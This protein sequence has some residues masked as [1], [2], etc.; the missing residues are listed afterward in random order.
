MTLSAVVSRACTLA[1]F[2]FLA[3]MQYWTWLETAQAGRQLRDPLLPSMLAA[4]AVAA[5][6]ATVAIVAGVVG[7]I[8]RWWHARRLRRALAA[9]RAAEARQLARTLPVVVSEH[10]DAPARVIWRPDDGIFDVADIEPVCRMAFDHGAQFVIV[11]MKPAAEQAARIL[12]RDFWP[13]L[14]AEEGEERRC[15]VV[16]P[17]ATGGVITRPLPVCDCPLDGPPELFVPARAGAR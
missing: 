2:V 13:R 5:V 1:G 12:I 9:A 6:V 4:L 16:L 8:R 7:A 3:V 14:C 10:P 15:P 17:M 11:E